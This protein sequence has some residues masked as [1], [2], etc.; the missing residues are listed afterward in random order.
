M[1]TLKCLVNVDGLLCTSL[2][3]WDIALGLTES[4]G[5]LGRNLAYVSYPY[6]HSTKPLL[7]TRLLSSTSILF[8]RTTCDIVSMC[9]QITGY[10]SHCTYKGEVGGIPRRSLDQ[11]LVSPAVQRLETLGVVDIVYEDAAVGSSVERNA[12]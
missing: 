2:K 10:H 5:S 4:H 8:P 12:Q 9:A 6:L 3:V 1:H 7:T 11:E